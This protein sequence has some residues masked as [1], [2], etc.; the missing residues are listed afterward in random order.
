MPGF[1]EKQ[2]QQKVFW[3]DELSSS[4]LRGVLC[5]HHAALIQCLAL[6]TLQHLHST[7][8]APTVPAQHF[9]SEAYGCTNHLTHKDV[10]G[11]SPRVPA[12]SL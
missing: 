4:T 2:L 9:E 6:T 3:Q 11:A 12:P 8:N 7:D 1:E 10:Q 5:Q